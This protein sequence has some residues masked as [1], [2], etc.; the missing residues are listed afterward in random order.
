MSD[1]PDRNRTEALV[2]ALGDVVKAHYLAGGSGRPSPG[3]V[4][5]ALNGLACITA[6]VIAGTAPDGVEDCVAFFTDA[7]AQQLQATL[8]AIAERA[9]GGEPSPPS[10]LH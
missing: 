7:T 8:S 5:E 10:P 1:E 3:R 2:H 6:M 4:F 9:K